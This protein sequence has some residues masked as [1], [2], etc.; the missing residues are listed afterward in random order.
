MASLASFNTSASDPDEATGLSIVLLAFVHQQQ[1]AKTTEE[2]SREPF[3]MTSLSL[4]FRAS[5]SN[6][7]STFRSLIVGTVLL[8]SYALAEV[9]HTLGV[10]ADVRFDFQTAIDQEFD[11]ASLQI[12][13]PKRREIKK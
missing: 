2:T 7:A 12:F 8:S 3:N 11:C 4:I 1:V 10:E 6:M 9:S 13:P 5:R